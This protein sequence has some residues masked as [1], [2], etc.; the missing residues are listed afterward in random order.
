LKRL[1]LLAS[2]GAICA[3]AAEI[4][5]PFVPPHLGTMLRIVRHVENSDKYELIPGATIEFSGM[6]ERI[7]PPV[8]WQI[9]DQ[10]IRADRLVAPEPDRVRIATYGDSET[11]G[12]SVALEDTFQRRMEQIDPR[13]E[14]LNFGVPGFNAEN[15]AE[16]IETTVPRF[17]PDLVIYLVNSNDVDDPIKISDPILSSELLLRVRFIYQVIVSKP[18]RKSARRSPERYAFLARQFDRIAGFAR[19]ER[20]PLFF[21]FM[22]SH[23]LNGVR[24]NAVPGGFTATSGDSPP[25]D[26]GVIVVNDLLSSQARIDDHLSSAAHGALAERLCSQIAEAAN[27]CVPASFDLE[28]VQ[29][30]GVVD[31]LARSVGVRPVGLGR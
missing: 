27:R 23:T 19:T 30:A 1:A 2:A 11:F 7:S 3:L 25:R 8:T 16:R 20:V 21:V 14:V 12:W 15:V 9:N 28:G 6:F 22:K 26:P 18:W 17:H 29:Q 13:L 10:G 31:S 4:V 5:L 24:E